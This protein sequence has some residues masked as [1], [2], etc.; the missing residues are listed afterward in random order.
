MFYATSFRFF[1]QL[2][3]TGIL[4]IQGK[5]QNNQSINQSTPTLFF[6]VCSAQG[7]VTICLLYF[8]LTLYSIKKWETTHKI[9]HIS[10]F[11]SRHFSLFCCDP[12]PSSYQSPGESPR[13]N[14][15]QRY[16][17]FFFFFAFLAR[18]LSDFEFPTPMKLT[19]S[20]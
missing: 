15:I 10:I 7:F 2:Y 14:W 4:P 17:D 6:Y 16:K 18:F 11:T 9:F 1:L 19:Q 20:L 8:G 12:S 5:T 3:M 13:A